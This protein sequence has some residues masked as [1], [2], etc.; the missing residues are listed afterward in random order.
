MQQIVQVCKARL[1]FNPHPL[2]CACRHDVQA[3]LYW[4]VI[5]KYIILQHHGSELTTYLSRIA[6][7]V[8]L[9]T[10]QH[11]DL[12][13]QQHL[14][15]QVSVSLLPASLS[16][17]ISSSSFLG[18]LVHIFSSQ[19]FSK[20]TSTLCILESSWL[21]EEAVLCMGNNSLGSLP[22]V[23]LSLYQRKCMQ[24]VLFITVNSNFLRK[25]TSRPP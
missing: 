25:T 12:W 19:L 2:S 16:I 6:S 20:S 22:V 1:N 17:N 9:K 18:E 7:L 15:W 5:D 21:S 8:F 13:Q 3:L 4:F 10:L 11:L 24:K 23:S 14:P